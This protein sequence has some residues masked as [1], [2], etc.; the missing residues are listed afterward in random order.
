MRDQ[1]YGISNQEL[2]RDQT[3]TKNAAAVLSSGAK[4][5]ARLD[6][7]PGMGGQGGVCEDTRALVYA[8]L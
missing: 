8:K 7:A 2:S 4:V 5:S 3:L 1:T 6:V